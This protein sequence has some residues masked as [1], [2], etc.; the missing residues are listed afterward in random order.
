MRLRN[1]IYSGVAVLFLILSACK[2]SKNEVATMLI[3]GGNIYT[4]DTIQPIVEAV[5][6]KDNIILFAGS[7]AEAEKFKTDQTQLINLEGKTMTPGLIEG[8]GHFMGLG[9]N[10]LNLD[11]MHTT[12]YQE[13]VAAVA[14]KVKTAAPG[15]WIT[16]RGWHQNKWKEMPADMVNGFQTHDLLSAVSP[17]NPVYL[18]HA[19]GHAGFANAKAMEIA[20]I[21]VLS[22]EGTNKFEVEGGEV[23]RDAMGRPTG[24][25][26]E[27]AEYLITKHIP[28]STP[29]K[30]IKAF[31]LAVA[32]CHRNGITGFHDAGIGRE[33]IAL[34][35]EMKTLDKMKIRLYGML[36][37]WDKELLSEWYEKGPMIDPDNLLTLR[38][39]KLNCDGA[40]GSRGAWLLEPY[41][42]RPGHFGHETLPME[43]VK[44]TALNGL[45]KGFQICSHAIGDRANREILDRYEAAFTALPTLATDHRFRIEHAQHLHP[46][47]IPRFAELGVIPAMQAIHMSSDRPW[48]IDRLGE[49]RIKEGAYMWQSLLQSGIP[50]VNGTDVPVEPMNPI[51][52]FYASVSRKTLEGSPEGGYEPAE[53]MTREQALRSYTL[54]AAYGAFEEDIKGSITVGKLADFT[55]FNQDLMKVAEKDLLNTTISMTIFDGKVVYEEGE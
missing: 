1:F 25:F 3:Y 30:D 11:L 49:Q 48:A 34:Y 41:T 7:L 51:A 5:A 53:K 50:I 18:R 21:T 35:K 42:D 43:F 36:T 46:D 19:S 45:Q 13:I 6:L 38:S 33:T 8:H 15:E 32:A 55:I 31:E 39:V 26:N 2:S 24:I 20:G 4:V 47:D 12:S 27:R 10:E 16:G 44:E 40:L 23:M 17:D 28:E 52:S 22:K 37:G 14:E 9:Y 29:E 54:D